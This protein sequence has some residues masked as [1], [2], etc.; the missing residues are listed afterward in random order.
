M[1]PQYNCEVSNFAD[2]AANLSL[3]KEARVIGLIR[4]K[5]ADEAVAL[6][7]AYF[8][9]G[10]TAVEVSFTTP[11]AEAVIEML[12][13]DDCGIVGA[14]TVLQPQQ[15]MGALAAGARFLVAPAQPKHLVPYARDAGAVS[16]LGGLTPNEIVSAMELGADFVKIFPVRAVGGPTYIRDIMA[17]LPD[18]PVLVSGGVDAGNYRQ[19]LEAGA[20]LALLGSALV[21]QELMDAK[22]WD[23]IAAHVRQAVYSPSPVTRR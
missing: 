11:D 7:R 4:C 3:L 17:P 15:A 20:S 1:P 12:A 23:G 10:M 19:Y 5:R 8:K 14:G 22:D 9:A 21:P 2:R 13:G 16:I 6:G 18:L